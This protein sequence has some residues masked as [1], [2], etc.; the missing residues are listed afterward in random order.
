[1]GSLETF[2]IDFV[3]DLSGNPAGITYAD[4]ANR[5]HVFDGHYTVNGSTAVFASTTGSI[6]NFAAFIDDDA[7][8]GTMWLA[9]AR[10]RQSPESR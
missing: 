5:D 4:A 9:T 8:V 3:T 2:R 10:P 6:V 1:M 7:V